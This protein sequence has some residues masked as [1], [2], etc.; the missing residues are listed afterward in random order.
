MLEAYRLYI[1]GETPEPVI[2]PSGALVMG[3]GNST[4]RAVTS[5]GN[6][7]FLSFYFENDGSTDSNR[8]QYLRLYLS[9]TDGGGEALR[10][11]TTINNVVGSTAHGAHI[12]LNFAD[13]GKVSGLGV[14]ARATLHIPNDGTMA[15]TMA[16]IQAEI[17]SDGSLSDPVGA[18]EL[19]FIRV[20]AGG[21]ADGIA[22]VEDDAFLFS[23]QG[24]TEGEGNLVRVAAPTTLAA[25][26]KVKVG[27]TTY[28][29]P[30]Y[31]AQS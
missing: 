13:T 14:A 28:Y 19:S 27:S 21:D 5:Q 9:G 25:S 6:K 3:I 23:L 8:G 17:W 4:A 26:L 20:V 31:S 29:L 24:F 10:A 15:G 18:T 2:S 16:A 1:S 30:L 11:F 22:D 7:N 12:S